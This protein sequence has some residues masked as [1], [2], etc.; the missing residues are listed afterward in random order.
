[1]SPGLWTSFLGALSVAGYSTWEDLPLSQK[2][3]LGAVSLVAVV[4]VAQSYLILCDPID[5]RP[6]GSPGGSDSKAS[7][8]SVGD[9]DSIPGLGRSPGEGNGNSLQC[10]C[11]ENSMDGGAW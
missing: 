7:A 4:L 9:L 5:Y 10:A 1:M 11:L 2:K 3:H 6:I 8:C